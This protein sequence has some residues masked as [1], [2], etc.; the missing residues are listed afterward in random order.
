MRPSRV[1][2]RLVTCRLDLASSRDF[3]LVTAPTINKR[4]MPFLPGRE[5]DGADLEERLVVAEVVDLLSC[6]RDG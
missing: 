4:G 3:R 2:S 6:G 1:S 5:R